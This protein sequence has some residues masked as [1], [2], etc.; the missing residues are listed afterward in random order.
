MRCE[1]GELTQKAIEVGEHQGWD[2]HFDPTWQSV[3][4]SAIGGYN[5]EFT[6]NSCGIRSK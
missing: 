4:V 1:P 2:I 6:K 5:A 3:R